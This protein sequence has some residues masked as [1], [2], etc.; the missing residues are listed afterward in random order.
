MSIENAIDVLLGKYGQADEKE[1]DAIAKA[2]RALEKQLSKK[3]S[4]ISKLYTGEKIGTCVCGYDS[5]L[6]HEKH[7]HN[8]GQKIDW[9]GL[10]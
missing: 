7:C 3:P 5:A 1:E 2:V 9:E 4:D 8:C 10:G 6:E